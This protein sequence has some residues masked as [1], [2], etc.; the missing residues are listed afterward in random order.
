MYRI[1][2]V[3]INDG[4]S[5]LVGN[6]T[7]WLTLANAQA[8]YI[9][10][11]PDNLF[12]LV[13]AVT[14]DEH[15]S[16]ERLL[17]GQPYSGPDLTGANYALML[18]ALPQIDAALAQKQINLLIQWREYIKNIQAWLFSTTDTATIT[19]HT[20]QSLNVY[21]P[22]GLQNLVP[23]LQDGTDLQQEIQTLSE[24]LTTLGE[25]VTTNDQSRQTGDQT[26]QQN[27]DTLAQSLGEADTALQQAIDALTQ[28][29]GQA[30]ATLQQNIDTLGQ[31]LGEADTTL[32]Q[33]IDTLSQSLTTINQQLSD[34]D[35]QLQGNIDSGDTAS[36]AH[37]LQNMP[38][39]PVDSPSSLSFL[40]KRY[41]GYRE[42]ESLPASNDGQAVLV[43][44]IREEIYLPVST[45][46]AQVPKTIRSRLFFVCTR[47]YMLRFTSAYT[48]TIKARVYPIDDTSVFLPGAP[49]LANNQ[50]HEIS[51]SVT[52][53]YKF[54]WDDNAGDGFQGI[55]DWVRL[56]NTSD[57]KE[58]WVELSSNQ[59]SLPSIGAIVDYQ[60]GSQTQT[61]FQQFDLRSDGYWY[62]E[63]ITPAA[64]YSA[65]ASWE[66]VAG[67]LLTYT[68]TA[69]T[70]ETDALQLFAS[71]TY[72]LYESELIV[73]TSKLTNSMAATIDNSE[74]NI[75]HYDGP[76]RF[77]IDK[78]RIYFKRASG[79]VSGTFA[80][81]SV[82]LRIPNA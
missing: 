44:P 18:T 58:K 8:G 76:Y 28:S 49:V 46:F 2:T 4:D 25:T 10:T 53:L 20:G 23:P 45:G 6:G 42:I 19:T 16:I 14:D 65:G 27:L 80:I 72:D 17:D 37:A 5:V 78:Q 38:G 29:T 40:L 74:P 41:V 50:W 36:R 79:A 21:T 54:G 81:E 55:I 32:Q 75:M 1:G 11:L 48:G 61:R 39:M 52:S 64:A 67:E 24:S 31:S 66:Q 68:A 47:G 13:T 26:L 56:E 35:T 60:F 71:N 43:D 69:A 62:G 63:D 70:D 33:N 3:S 73:V 15:I 22:T 9:V 57:G 59:S 30:D 34:A 82:R 12:Y 51:A 77:L 7:E